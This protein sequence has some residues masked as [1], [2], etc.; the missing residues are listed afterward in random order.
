MPSHEQELEG[1]ILQGM[2]HAIWGHA[3]IQWATNV[4]PPSDLHG[5]TWAEVTP[6]TDP[7]AMKAAKEFSAGIGTLN[8]LGV[9]PMVKMFLASRR[10]A[11]PRRSSTRATEADQAFQFGSDV[12]QACLGTLDVPEIGQYKLPEM[13]AEL[14]DDGTHLS[15]DEGWLWHREAPQ[16]NPGPQGV[17][18][19]VWPSRNPGRVA[20]EVPLQQFAADVNAE[21]PYVVAER[22][23]GAKGRFGDRKV[24]IAAVWRQLRT[25]PAFDGMT[26]AKFKDRLVEAHRQR[27]L[28]LARADLV[29]AMDSREVAESEWVDPDGGRSYHFV[30]DRSVP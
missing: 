21:L 17:R 20:P 26:L 12:A 18:A 16:P 14:D 6:P 15:W 7:S 23:D 8:D 28:E 4:E 1:Y 29:A 2:A 22:G 27:L 9:R 10:Y 11:Q 30:V 5:A 3:F 24:F 13:K 19:R 25:S